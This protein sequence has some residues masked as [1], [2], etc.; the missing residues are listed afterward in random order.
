[1]DFVLLFVW[2]IMCFVLLVLFLL[3][4][5]ERIC[6]A[7]EADSLLDWLQVDSFLGVHKKFM[8]E[9]QALIKS[10]DWDY[11]NSQLL[12]N[13]IK[14]RLLII[15]PQVLSETDRE[16]YY[17]TLW[18]WYHHAIS[19]AIRK[20]DRSTAQTYANRA[21]LM[22]QG[23]HPNQI[24]RFLW[25]LVHDRVKEAESYLQSIQHPVEKQAG[26]ELLADYKNGLFFN[27]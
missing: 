3:H 1:M 14:S 2:V 16:W 5:I 10:G 12:I 6:S 13:K 17:E 23:N 7:D 18:I 24:T 26:V 27:K 4:K 15:N 25:F 9:D 11:N 21:L 20:K 8:V 19:C 22:Q